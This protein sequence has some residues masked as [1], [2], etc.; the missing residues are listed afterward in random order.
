MP[1]VLVR[2]ESH[3]LFSFSCL[4]IS[5]RLTT[6]AAAAAIAASTGRIVPRLATAVVTPPVSAVTVEGMEVFAS[7]PRMPE[8]PLNS[9]RPLDTI[10][11]T[12]LRAV[13]ARRIVV[14]SV[15]VSE[16]M[17]AMNSR[18]LP[19]TSTSFSIAGRKFSARADPDAK[20]AACIFAFSWSI[21][22]WN[23]CAPAIAS[24]DRMRPASS[25]SLPYLQRA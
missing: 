4:I 13:P 19:P 25:A 3:L 11:S 16:S 9:S 24:P 7:V 10:F 12:G 6:V 5:I 17:F 14:I 15:S 20:N 21:A 22:S 1:L 2:Y 18:T 8:T 23:F